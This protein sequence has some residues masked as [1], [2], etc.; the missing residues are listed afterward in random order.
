MK[1]DYA[2][3]ETV[4]V[5]K[6]TTQNQSGSQD[7]SERVTQNPKYGTSPPIP[8]MPMSLT[9][10]AE[11]TKEPLSAT[12]KPATLVEHTLTSKILPTPEPT[13]FQEPKNF[14]VSTLAPETTSTGKSTPTVKKGRD[15]NDTRQQGPK[16]LYGNLKVICSMYMY[17]YRYT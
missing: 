14:S 3:T 13:A 9:D 16:G 5:M 17:T 2:F 1:G 11:S 4:P 12:T 10:T 6:V 7:A 8:T 15:V